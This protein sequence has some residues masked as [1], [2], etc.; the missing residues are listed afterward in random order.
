VKA[1]PHSSAAV[2]T[3]NIGVEGQLIVIAA[4]RAAI[5]GAVTSCTFIL[6]D[7]VDELPHASVAVHVLV[8][9][10]D[11]AHA[12]ELLT[13][14]DVRVNALPHASFAVATANT[15]V[16]GQLMVVVVGSAAITGAVTSC[17]FILC[18]AVDEL[19][20]AS[21]AVHILVTLYDPAH[22]PFVVTSSDVRVKALPHAS[23]AVATANT[24]VA[25]QS[26]VVVAGNAAMTGAVIS[27][28]CIICDAVDE[29]PQ[30]SV[31]VHVRVTLYEP[32]HAPFV[33]TSADVSV[34]A[35]PQASVAVACIKTGTSGQLIVAGPRS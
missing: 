28:T 26:I 31:A 3:A 7:A 18:E 25:G 19:P 22:A 20:H 4:G 6:C 2:A 10:Y 34:N 23:V 14:S 12:P 29:L 1:L 27:C 13:S 16:A 21:V 35:L 33:V 5:T 32:A 9:L 11:P 17:T 15:G 30:A 24:G 8:T